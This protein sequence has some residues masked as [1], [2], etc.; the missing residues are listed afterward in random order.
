V[1]LLEVKDLR[2]TISGRKIL[3]GVSFTFKPGTVTAVMG[4]SGSGKSTLLR[5]LNRLLELVP[6]A[7][8]E[9]QVLLD[10]EDVY[11]MNP[12]TVRR[13]IGMVFQ[14][15]N[16][17]PHISIYDNV[18]LAP[19]LHG[20]AKSREELDELVEWALRK[21][22]LWDEVKDRLHRPPTELSGGQQQRLSLARA[23][24][25][26]PEVLLLDEP[27]ANIDPVNTRKIEESIV[28]FARE[29]GMTVVIVTHTPQQAVR[30]SD[31]ILFLYMG[32]QVEAGPTRS[33]ALEP[34]T[35]LLAQYFKGEL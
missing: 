27:T 35:R 25:A 7:R 11:R 21:A 17:F 33:L 1:G 34:R 22:M 26:R 16:P 2:V 10:G 15:P 12:Y 18:A 32:R 13:R 4:P 31:H 30:I 9:G 29:L 24:A 6:G 20:L 14:S 28:S 5:S 19:R 3:E 8:V 23:I